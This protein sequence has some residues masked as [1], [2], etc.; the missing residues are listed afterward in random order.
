MN[1]TSVKEKA[2]QAGPHI[3]PRPFDS[4]SATYPM[5]GCQNVLTDSGVFTAS[6][7]FD[8]SQIIS[9]DGVDLWVSAA[10]RTKR[11]IPGILSV[12]P[13]GRWQCAYARTDYPKLDGTDNSMPAVLVVRVTP[14][15]GAPFAVYVP[16]CHDPAAAPRPAR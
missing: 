10:D 7:S 2:R 6:G 14:T 4:V 12:F 13:D 1:K 16:F 8:T 5:P 9:I 3:R 15:Q 11:P